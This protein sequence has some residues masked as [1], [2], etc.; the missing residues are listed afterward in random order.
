MPATREPTLADPPL[1]VPYDTSARRRTTLLLTL[2]TLAGAWLRLSHLG[3]K[4]LWLDEGATVALARASW[5]HFAWVWWHGE[6]S[7]Q[8]IYFLLMRGWGH[9]GLSEAWLRL[10]S[11]LFGIAS[12]PL[13]YVVARKFAVRSAALAA[14]ALLTFSPAHVFYSQEAR[15]YALAILLVLLAT[16]FF[17]LAVEHDRTRDW[18]LWTIF[19]IASFYTH[20]FT[21]LVLVAQAASLFF[22]T[23]PAPWRRMLICSSI[24]LL[25]AIPGLTYV[26]RASPENLY[27]VWMPR[28]TPK[29]IWH[30]AMFLGGSGVKVALALVLWIAGTV[31]IFRNRRAGERDRFWRGMLVLLWMVLPAAILGLVSLREPLF[32]QRY[33]VFSLPAAVLLAALG[34]A[35]LPKW[36]LGQVLVIALCAA[37][38]PSIA[39]QYREPREDWR[40]AGNAVLT[41][42]APGDAV[43]FFPFYTRSMFD[44]Y[45]DRYGAAAPPLHV[46]AP[47]FYAGGEDARNLLAALSRDPH[48]FR[49]VWV[50]VSDHG[51][52]LQGFDH[53]A[54]VQQ[55]LQTI[56]GAP[57]VRRF[58][59]I[60]VLQY[61]DNTFPVPTQ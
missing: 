40:G 14:A 13:L 60:D 42:A 36:K 3:A 15:S 31:A 2:L 26:L 28:A 35:S 45:R 30:L 56:F 47:G 24:I 5:R 50:F 19:G 1:T 58:A 6:A 34:M 17:V 21:A 16:Y 4:S 41:A 49:H 22:K 54:S 32:L 55:K 29:Q 37:S 25:A 61:G 44:Y 43:V 53:G 23:P 57:V 7:L 18:A 51:G 11:A 39:K 27:F 33:M 38:L 10:P 46:F 12:I 59:D 52:S 20:D 48:Q 8:T 9:L